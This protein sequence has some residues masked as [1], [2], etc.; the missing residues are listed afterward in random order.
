MIGLIGKKVGMTQIFDEKGTLIPVTVIG[1]EPNAVIEER[2]IEKH[3][4]SA[5]VLGAIEKKKKHTTKPYAGQFKEGVTPKKKLFEIRNFEG[6]HKVGDMLGVDIFND[7]RKVDVIGVS[8]GKGYQGVV[9]RHKFGGGR[10]THGSKFHNAVGSV[11]ASAFPSRSMKGLKMPG[12]MGPK[13]VTVKNLNIVRVDTERN[14]L[15]VEGAVPTHRGRVVKIFPI[16][17]AKK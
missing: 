1:I 12:R 8:K 5:L 11:G 2:T 4:Y 14:V 7:I 17:G 15:C 9:K 6:E 16:E 13:N 10:K 3:G